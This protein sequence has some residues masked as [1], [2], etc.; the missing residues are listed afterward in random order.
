MEELQANLV[1]EKAGAVKMGLL[2]RIVNVVVSPGKVME[3]LAARPRVIF[4]LIMIAVTQLAVILARFPLYQ[5]FL[6]KSMEASSE[7]T[8]SLTGQEMTP[9]MVASAVARSSTQAIV[10][11]P[12][13]ALFMWLVTTVIFFAIIKIGGGKGKFKQYF[14]VVGYAYVIQLLFWLITLAVSFVTG[15]L[16]LDMPLTSIGNLF[17][18]GMKGTFVF[19]MIKGI[20]LFTIWYYAVISIGLTIVSGF[21]K[22]SI[23]II[24]GAVFLIGLL[25]AGASEAALGAYM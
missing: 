13:M 21:R 9:E 11:T 1:N 3:N 23:Y 6:R 14:S 24:V 18:T 25:I 7:F 19:G 22:R 16:H 8:K 4:P 20:E 15:S 10:T 5:D 17:G 12:L 2:Q